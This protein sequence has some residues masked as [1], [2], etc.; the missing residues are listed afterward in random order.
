MENEWSIRGGLKTVIKGEV[1]SNDVYLWTKN[2]Q[3]AILNGILLDANTFH[4]TVLSEKLP[5]GDFKEISE[6]ENFS[7]KTQDFDWNSYRC[8]SL[9]IDLEIPVEANFRVY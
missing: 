5:K 1:T 3:K 7:F 6:K 2:H 8:Y 9:V 4:A